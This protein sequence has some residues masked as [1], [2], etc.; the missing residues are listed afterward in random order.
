VAAVDN[1]KSSPRGLVIGFGGL[2]MQSRDP[3]AT[4][5]WYRD[6]L[7]MTMNDYG[8]FDFLHADSAAYPTAART[9]FTAFDAG[10]E[11][12]SP[13]AR[14]Y[15]INLIVDDLDALLVRARGA[16]VEP[17][18]PT[19][20]HDYGRFAWFMDPDDRKVELWEPQEPC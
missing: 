9:V 3:G 11:Y 16:G 6:V 5:A 17:V 12:F 4:H 20:T 1:S 10:S 18:Q 19:E 8:G 2:F 13:S 7:G 15:M 14:D